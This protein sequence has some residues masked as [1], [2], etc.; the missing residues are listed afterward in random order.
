MQ[1]FTA[2]FSKLSQ[3]GH[4]FRLIVLKWAQE[5]HKR[6]KAAGPV[7]VCRVNIGYIGS[8]ELIM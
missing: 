8:F 6:V 5:P 7:L 2:T 4:N 1:H 3:A